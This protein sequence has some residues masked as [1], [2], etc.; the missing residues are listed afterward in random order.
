MKQGRR[1]RVEGLA[2]NPELNGRCGVICGACMED[3]G[4]WA[5]LIDA[6]STRP[7]CKGHFRP[8]N[9]KMTQIS[10]QL[11]AAVARLASL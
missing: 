2:A 8:A 3:S 7:S 5:V 1:V 11:C 6:D 4:R 9:L 10:V